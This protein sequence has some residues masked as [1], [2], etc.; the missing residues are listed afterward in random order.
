MASLSLSLLGTFQA[1]TVSGEAQLFRTQK[2]RALLAFLA[3]EHTQAHAREDISRLL[4][5]ERS[6]GI[7]RNNLRQALFGLRQA[8]GEREFT[9]IFHVNQNDI[10]FNLGEQV[11]L[12][13][14]VFELH[15]KAYQAHNQHG[16]QP[17]SYCLQHLRDAVEIYRGDF[18]QDLEMDKNAELH[19][20][21]SAQRER[22][23]QMQV[24]SL[25]N[26]VEIYESS[27]DPSSA[28]LYCMRLVQMDSLNEANYRRLMSLLAACGRFSAALEQY[29]ICL[30]RFAEMD[31]GSLNPETTRLA[32]N[33][34]QGRIDQRSR[35]SSAPQNN[36]PEHLTPFIGREMELA[37]MSRSLHDPLQRLISVTGSGGVGKTRFAVQAALMHLALFPD[38]VFF[39]PLDALNHPIQLAETIGRAAGLV[40]DGR[41]DPQEILLEYLRLRRVLL[42]IDNFEHLL[43]GR[44]FLLKLLRAAPFIKLLVTSREKL[45]LQSEFLYELEGLP[46]HPASGKAHVHVLT[47]EDLQQMTAVALLLERASR[48]RVDLISPVEAETPYQLNDPGEIEGIMRICDLVDGLPLGIELAASWAHTYS[49]AQI[50]EE[51]QG[52]L[53]FL[54]ASLHDLPPRHR[55]LYVSFEHSWNFL[56]STE[57]E[58]FCKL[59]VF[60]SSFSA[61]AAQ[62]VAGASF[63]CLTGLVDKSLVRRLSFGRYIFHPLIRQYASQKLRLFSRKMEDQTRHLYAQH[64]CHLLQI[65]GSELRGNAQEQALGILQAELDNLYVAWDWAVE[66]ATYELL[67]QASPGLFLFLETLSRWLE[68]EERFGQAITA[69]RAGQPDDQ[70]RR[71]LAYLLA[72]QGWFS[73][74]L[75]NYALA[76]QSLEQS[77]ACF[78]N[79]APS[80]ER[81]FAQFALGFLKVWLGQFQEAWM[82]LST[83]LMLSESGGDEWSAAWAREVLAEVAYESG[84]SG[85]NNAPFLANLAIFE[86]LG[87]K[88][89]SSRVLNYLGIIAM[90]AERYTEAQGY[91]ERLL[92]SVEKLGDVWGEAGGYNK[93]GQLAAAQGDNSQAWRYLQRALLLLQKTGDQR[94]IAYLQAELG[95]ICAVSGREQEAEDYFAHALTLAQRTQNTALVQHVFTC[96]A[97]SLLRCQQVAAASVLLHLVAS[98]PAADQATSRRVAALMQQITAE[99][100]QSAPP[101]SIGGAGEKLWHEARRILDKNAKKNQLA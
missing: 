62:L 87:D 29:D 23:R 77:L 99:D 50:A 47:R 81:A 97:A 58:V 13:S 4:W 67:L 40:F 28:A 64:Y 35:Y 33:I 83:C 94:R 44:D 96:R 56:S 86:R 16:D 37:R 65:C 32:E 76:Q 27:A 34:R 63:P 38:G 24:Q 70:A 9:L 89:G 6:E 41:H 93:L 75:S 66:H 46:Y 59:A 36:L 10:Q 11:W 73:C 68:G 43:E 45:A 42:V 14:V 5:P 82:H 22:Y 74:R 54:G 19:A 92:A 72:C 20:W 26:L 80:T 60:P 30:R 12:D 79:D 17:C 55:S 3:V 2:E 100:N 25:R 21:I 51:I 53:D 88:R 49:F 71:A 52:S 57:Q 98:I 61:A 78:H 85:G 39:V 1:W 31:A 18:L 69:L 101:S 7:G 91:F 15:V 95:E 8:I 48:V 84:Q 90:L